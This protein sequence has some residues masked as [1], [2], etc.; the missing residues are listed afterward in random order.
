MRSSSSG[1]AGGGSW[2][3]RNKAAEG[4]GS[5]GP[6]RTPGQQASSCAGGRAAGGDGLL[7][8]VDGSCSVSGSI[9]QKPNWPPRQP[10]TGRSPQLEQP[11]KQ[12]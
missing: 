5:L 9:D 3:R 2:W 7:E 6:A 12:S 10:T 11:R 4:R 8:C 1:A